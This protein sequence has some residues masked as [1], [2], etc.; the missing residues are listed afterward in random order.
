MRKL[1]LEEDKLSKAE[2]FNLNEDLACLNGVQ[3]H[4]F[5]VDLLKSSRVVLSRLVLQYNTQTI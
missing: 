2:R 5:V 3:E 1:R 4:Q